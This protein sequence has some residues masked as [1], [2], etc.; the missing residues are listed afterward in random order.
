MVLFFLS[1]VKG[2]IDDYLDLNPSQFE[3]EMDYTRGRMDYILNSDIMERG[4]DYTSILDGKD[5]EYW[6]RDEIYKS[7]RHVKVLDLESED[8]CMIVT[9]KIGNPTCLLF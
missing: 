7:Y 6:L 4:L 2:L 3:I 9:I 5:F 8:Q 1:T